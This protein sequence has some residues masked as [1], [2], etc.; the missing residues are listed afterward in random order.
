M[1]IA[2]RVTQKLRHWSRLTLD[3]SLRQHWTSLGRMAKPLAAHTLES[4]C[5]YIFVLSTGRVGTQTLA[6][7]ARLSP[8]L[9]AYHEPSPYLYGLSKQAYLYSGNDVADQVLVEALR[10]AR[11]EQWSYSKSCAKGYIET[12]PQTTFLAPMIM[13]I[14]PKAKFIHLTRHPK[15][16]IRSGMN[17]GW[18]AGHI[19]DATRIEP[20]VD[21]INS[22]VI[23][24]GAISSD[25]WLSYT[26]LQKNIWLWA[27]TNR[28]ILDFCATLPES[29]TLTLRAESLFAGEA[30]F[31][32]QFYAFINAPIPPKKQIEKVLN[33]RLNQNVRGDFDEADEWADNM[34]DDLSAFVATVAA[35]LRYDLFCPERADR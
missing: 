24:S 21:A 28:W 4:D 33:K 30:D 13:R 15:M 2:D 16:V 19:S 25:A 17:R 35:A 12:S 1:D 10:C 31:I 11:E 27:E 8:N 34:G 26:P 22:S 3:R 29:Q 9:L 23:N 14:L 7:L 32:Q 6:D 18:Y 5:P 20:S